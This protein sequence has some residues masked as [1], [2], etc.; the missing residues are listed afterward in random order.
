M[1]NY[2]LIP[3]WV[4]VLIIVII[5]GMC[6]C[7]GGRSLNTGSS[8][9]KN[10]ITPS[11]PPNKAE[12]TPKFKSLPPPPLVLPPIKPIVITN[13]AARSTPVAPE[14]KPIKAKPVIV[15]PRPAGEKLEPFSPTVNVTPIITDGNKSKGKP[16]N[17][18]GT[19]DSEIAGPCEATPEEDMKINWTEL[20]M[21]YGTAL[22]LLAICV[23]V[24]Q[25]VT[26]KKGK[27]SKLKK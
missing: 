11:T 8:G 20:I 27:K 4:L 17:W 19:K 10:V 22:M 21:F 9:I 15:D 25:M 16:D 13:K 24:Y 26:K 12:D 23:M 18:C 7:I 2:R 1:Q 14:H 6:A 5:A 3:I